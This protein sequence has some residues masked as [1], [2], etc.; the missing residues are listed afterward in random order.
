MRTHPMHMRAAQVIFVIR[1]MTGAPGLELPR[2]VVLVELS[3]GSELLLQLVMQDTVV[4]LAQGALLLVDGM[5]HDIL[6]LIK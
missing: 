2:D 5:P 6:D 3:K 1:S 4:L